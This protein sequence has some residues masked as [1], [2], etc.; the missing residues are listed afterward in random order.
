MEKIKI[1]AQ[2]DKLNIVK[3][4]FLVGGCGKEGLEFSDEN[5]NSLYDEIE[6]QLG[7]DSIVDPDEYLI[8]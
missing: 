8:K 7:F 3:I 1:R 2:T 6:K 5:L 4:M